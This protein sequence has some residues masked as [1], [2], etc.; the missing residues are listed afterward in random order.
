MP[1]EEFKE[2]NI[3]HNPLHTKNDKGLSTELKKY[4]DNNNKNKY[5]DIDEL[6]R[7][8]KTILG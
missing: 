7:I 2:R 6:S 5:E 1:V 3:W 8:K 4:I